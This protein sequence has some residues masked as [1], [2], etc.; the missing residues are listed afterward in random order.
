MNAGVAEA[1]TKGL[2]K[3][4][5]ARRD[6][7]ITKI[8]LSVFNGFCRAYTGPLYVLLAAGATDGGSFLSFWM[9]VKCLHQAL[10]LALVGA[11]G[12]SVDNGG[13]AMCDR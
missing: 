2:P 12:G 13:G 8:E 5:G 10:R 11:G 9:K 1:L 7:H 4:S 3:Y 6:Y